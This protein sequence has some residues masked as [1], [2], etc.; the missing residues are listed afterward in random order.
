MQNTAC[1]KEDPVL[2]L[3]K[4]HKTRA[5]HTTLTYIL[6]I[7][8]HSE[9]PCRAM[10]DIQDALSSI[11]DASLLINEPEFYS[12]ESL[13]EI[14]HHEYLPASRGYDPSPVHHG[15]AAEDTCNTIMQRYAALR[16][17]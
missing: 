4:K 2:H 12:A 17:S 9:K 15:P 8:S 14:A 6:T 10:C 16:S 7:F 5:L 3:A 1:P 11:P 13:P